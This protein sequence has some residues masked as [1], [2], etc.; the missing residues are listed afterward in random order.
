MQFTTIAFAAL[1]LVLDAS[2]TPIHSNMTEDLQARVRHSSP[3]SSPFRS[4]P[5]TLMNQQIT[6]VVIGTGFSDNGPAPI[7]MTL[8]E[9]A[10]GIGLLTTPVNGVTISA[11]SVQAAGFVQAE[12]IFGDLFT[13]GSSLC[14]S[15]TGALFSVLSNFEGFVRVF[16]SPQTCVSCTF[17]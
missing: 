16:P 15:T 12:C 2:A 14:D 7:T 9:P 6:T 11:E 13:P 10:F 1:T 5:L 8:S 17:T 3:I 4:A